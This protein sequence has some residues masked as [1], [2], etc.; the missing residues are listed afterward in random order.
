VS[1]N[2]QVALEACAAYSGSAS[3]CATNT[4][5]GAACVGTD[6]GITGELV[7]CNFLAAMQTCVCWSYQGAHLGWVV[8]SG[9]MT[10]CTYPMG[11]AGNVAYH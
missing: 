2:A 7:V 9:L 3:N 6:G 8:D 10:E 5:F 1:I 4:A 11:G